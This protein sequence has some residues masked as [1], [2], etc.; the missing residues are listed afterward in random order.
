M[1][2]ELKRCPRCA[3]IK[4]LE[5]F[6]R[7]KRASSGLMCWCKSCRREKGRT[8]YAARNPKRWRDGMREV[9]CRYYIKNKEKIKFQARERDKNNPDKA[10]AKHIK[11]R[12]KNIKKALAMSEKWRRAHLL[13]DAMNSQRRRSRKKAASIVRFGKQ[14]LLNRLSMFPGC[15]V[16]GGQKEHVDHV[17]PLAKGGP[18][19]LSNLRPIC[20]SCNS[21][22]H[23]K[24]P[25]RPADI[26][27][28]T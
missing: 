1:S 3:Q 23:S 26:F 28:A 14:A 10:R 11:W 20:R 7:D 27:A 16:C 13:E 15:W 9:H 5:N 6:G 4:T 17:K 22:K 2:L 8:Y 21:K 25:F 18:H 19:C 24:W 12:Q